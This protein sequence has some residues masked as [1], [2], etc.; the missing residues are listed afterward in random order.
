MTNWLPTIPA[1]K[2]PMYVRLADQIADDIST[3]TL[4]PGTKLPPQ[5]NVAYDLGVTVGTIGRAYALVRERGLVSGEVGRGTYVLGSPNNGPEAASSSNG[6]SPSSTTL[7]GTSAAFRQTGGAGTAQDLE[8][9]R[10]VLPAP[11]MIRMDSTSAPNVGLQATVIHDLTNAITKEC[12]HEIASY[13]RTKPDSW[14]EAGQT[15]LA[16][17]GW[18]PDAL[19]VIPTLGAHAAIIAVIAAITSPG[20][21]IVFEELTY[22]SIAR[23]VAMTGR[24][25]VSVSRD[26]AGPLP[27]E[28]DR[29]C[30][31]MHPKAIFVMPT[32][33]NPTLATMDDTRRKDLVEVARQHNLWILEDE[34]Y[35]S[36]RPTTLRPIAALAP[37]RTFHVGSLSKT[38]AAGV[39]G[40]WVACAPGQVQRVMT[41]HKLLTGGISFLLAELSA[42][43]VLSG[44]A[45]NLRQRVL[46]TIERR[47]AIALDHLAG[48]EVASA[49]D[50][51]FLWLKLPEP[52]LPGTFKAAAAAESVLIDDEDEFK[53]GRSERMYHRVRVGFTNPDTDE[54]VVR[55]FTALRGLLHDSTAAYDS[56]E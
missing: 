10:S 3:G 9:T 44:E 1:G 30:S 37:E 33:H 50:A 51:P 34:V 42:R 5:R 4:P 55:A 47:H 12:A 25:P 29:L 28:L 38:V 15:W 49:P 7:S 16:R 26:A 31:Q 11:G 54:E 41:A 18:E 6:F 43:L 45:H 19:S 8:G 17:S 27:D 40:G 2:G 13:T 20:D 35:G 22:S 46:G 23:A 36:L 32:M 56:F 24:Q 14:R 48:M 39:R 52:W 53:T 21:R